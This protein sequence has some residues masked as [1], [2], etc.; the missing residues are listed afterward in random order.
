MAVLTALGASCASSPTRCPWRYSVVEVRWFARVVC[1]STVPLSYTHRVLFREM[2]VTLPTLGVSGVVDGETGSSSIYPLMVTRGLPF[3]GCR[4]AT[5]YT[6][7]VRSGEEEVLPHPSTLLF[8]HTECR[9]V[10]SRITYS[11]S[12]SVGCE[13]ER[14]VPHPSMLRILPQNESDFKSSCDASYTDWVG[15]VSGN[16]SPPLLLTY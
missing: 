3:C 16:G 13:M 1:P 14:L 7:W 8:K 4:C 5:T 6:D 9:S 11:V 12:D 15:S 10:K 2:T